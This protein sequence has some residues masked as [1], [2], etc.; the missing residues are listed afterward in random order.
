[1]SCVNA[2]SLATQSNE[3]DSG[4]DSECEDKIE[5]DLAALI[6]DPMSYLDMAD[7]DC[8]TAPSDSTCDTP[9]RMHMAVAMPK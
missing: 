9:D 7:E 4:S 6:A 8:T 3:V 5:E 2:L 1:M